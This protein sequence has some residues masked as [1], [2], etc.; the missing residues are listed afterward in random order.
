MYNVKGTLKRIGK[1]SLNRVFLNFGLKKIK[2]L[3]MLGTEYGGWT[4]PVNLINE[5]SICYCV[6]AG[7]DISFDCLLAEKFHCKVHIFDPTPRSNKHISKLR[8]S[9]ENNKKMAT[10]SSDFYSIKKENLS[11]LHFYPYGIWDTDEIKKFY[12]PRDP[13]HVSHSILNLQKTSNY[14]EAECKKI[15]SIMETLDHDKINLLKLDIEGAE[16]K[17][18]ESIFRSNIF[19]KILC[20]EF[21]EIHNPSD[22]DYIKRIRKT[23]NKIKQKGYHLVAVEKRSDFTFVRF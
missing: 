18:I 10:C 17:V 21:D 15:S 9:V 16:Y 4:I 6:G 2:Y 1:N 3:E 13:N 5:N 7:E 11:L 14:F 19:P 23:V 22:L 12:S 8:E 20:V